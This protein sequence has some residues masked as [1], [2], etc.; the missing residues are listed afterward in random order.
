MSKNRDNVENARNKITTM[1][2]ASIVILNSPL[3]GKLIK[4]TGNTNILS[5]GDAK[6]G[7]VKQI[8]FS[9]N[10]TIEH[11][12]VSLIL[13]NAKNIVTEIGDSAEFIC[14]SDNNW[15]LSTYSRI[16]NSLTASQLFLSTSAPSGGKHRDI[17]MRYL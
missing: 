11:N 15:K 2:S 7:T 6:E 9:G 8:E 14:I 5:F 1:A 16:N 4:I 13:P 3:S 17:W 12:S 10:M